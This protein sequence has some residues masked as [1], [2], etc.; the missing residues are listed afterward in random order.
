MTETLVIRTETT[1]PDTTMAVCADF[2][3]RIR[4][5]PVSIVLLI[6]EPGAGKTTFC[7]GFA[8]VM[9][10]SDTINSPTFNLHNRFVGR[11]G[12][13]HHYDLYRLESNDEI[14][15]LGFAEEWAKGDGVSTVHAIEW[16]QRAFPFL[17]HDI[18]VYTIKL[19]VDERDDNRRLIEIHTRSG[20][21]VPGP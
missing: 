7:R 11:L 19:T 16:G 13:L 18:P 15:A 17:P 21:I 10:I 1:T 6:G 20:K 3:A 5:N 2:F 14:D 12:T 8:Q 4:H 9:E